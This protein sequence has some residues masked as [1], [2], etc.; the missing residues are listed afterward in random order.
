V[1]AAVP[2]EVLE[3]ALSARKAGSRVVRI[4]STVDLVA[5]PVVLCKVEPA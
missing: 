5:Q 2:P 4:A 3:Q 1:R